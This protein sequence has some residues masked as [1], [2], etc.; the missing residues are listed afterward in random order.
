MQ[1][2]CKRPGFRRLFTVALMSLVLM[3][4]V[5]AAYLV[6]PTSMVAEAASVKKVGIQATID[7]NTWQIVSSVVHEK[8]ATSNSMGAA[9]MMHPTMEQRRFAAMT[10]NP[11]YLVEDEETGYDAL[12]VFQDIVESYLPDMK[13]DADF[14]DTGTVSSLSASILTYPDNPEAEAMLADWNSGFV[15]DLNLAFLFANGGAYN[16]VGS[17]TDEKLVSYRNDLTSF[18]G[19]VVQMVGKTTSSK[20]TYTSADGT[21]TAMIYGTGSGNT[22]TIEAN[23]EKESFAFQGKNLIGDDLYFHGPKYVNW[24]HVALIAFNSYYLSDESLR[25]TADNVYTGNNITDFEKKLVDLFNSIANWIK[26]SLGLWSIDDLVFNF[27][28]RKA[29]IYVGGLYPA[30]WERTVW[31]LFFVA[32]VAAFLVL[33][34]AIVT[35]VLRKVMSTVNPILR[36]SLMDQAKDLL[37][38]AFALSVLPLLLQ[39]VVNTSAT[40]TGIMGDVIEEGTFNDRFKMLSAQSG[41]LGGVIMQFLYLT[42][43]ILFNALYIIR[44]YMVVMLV[45]TAPIFVIFFAMGDNKKALGKLW[46]MELLSNIF[47]QPIHAFVLGTVL[48]LGGSSRPVEGLVML[49]CVLPISSVIRGLFFGDAGAS[50]WKTAQNGVRAFKGNAQLAWRTGAGLKNWATDKVSSVLNKGKGDKDSG[51][52]KASQEK[53]ES[54]EGRGTDQMASTMAARN[55]VGKAGPDGGP[56]V[57]NSQGKTP[58][59]EIADKIHTN[60]EIPSVGMEARVPTVAESQANK[61]DAVRAALGG[62]GVANTVSA[63]TA[64]Y[65]SRGAGSDLGDSIRQMP[66]PDGSVQYQVPRTEMREAGFEAFSSK[67]GGGSEFITTDTGYRG[68]S[69]SGEHSIQAA[70]HGAYNNVDAKNYADMAKVFASGTDAQKQALRNAGYDFVGAEMKGSTPTGRFSVATNNNFSESMGYQ[71][72]ATKDGGLNIKRFGGAE[73]EMPRTPDV[74]QI[75]NPD[76]YRRTTSDG[77][78]GY[79]ETGM[80][81]RAPEVQGPA[82]MP[83]NQGTQYEGGGYEIPAPAMQEMGMSFAPADNGRVAVTYDAGIIGQDAD[84]ATV[85]APE[86]KMSMPDRRSVAQIQQMWEQG[87]EEGRSYLQSQGI[88]EVIAHE[89]GQVTVLY[90]QKAQ[91]NMGGHMTATDSGHVIVQPT[92]TETPVQTVVPIQPIVPQQVRTAEPHVVVP[93]QMP[94][95]AYSME[96]AAQVKVAPIT[97]TAPTPAPQTPIVASA[98]TSAPTPTPTPT[99]ASTPTPAPTPAPAPSPQPAAPVPAPSVFSPTAPTAPYMGK[100]G[101]DKRMKR[102]ENNAKHKRR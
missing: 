36:V 89:Q 8:V 62:A 85:Y 76:A 57:F 74:Q 31:T 99:H 77:Q 49:Y 23:G 95:K 5:A 33:A 97:V 52:K 66:R 46:M 41:A 71:A 12:E 27:N 25:V 79:T 4:G 15:A 69:V 34:I 86:S 81:L 101:A 7:P 70:S 37:V 19:K 3:L 2:K 80:K 14:S 26:G 88:E 100:P 91:E 102:R 30:S 67:P 78:V 96:D 64:I 45:I 73:G 61:G 92:A 72:T 75:L 54:K 98:P 17:T 56:T 48:L 29:P 6:N 63:D 39:L 53:S 59:E 47:I 9:Q 13:Q 20:T 16:P 58:R 55:K 44:S 68:T 18:L 21:L 38:V 82:V 87:G 22:I 40:M 50:P 32:E 84:G 94:G 1:N 28:G 90:N 35:N 42:I 43:T 51:G 93:Q 10:I 60:G 11:D 65:T 83:I 24:G